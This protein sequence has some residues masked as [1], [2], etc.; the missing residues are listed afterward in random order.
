MAERRLQLEDVVNLPG[1]TH[2]VPQ[3]VR[4]AREDAHMWYLAGDTDPDTLVLWE[5]DLQTKQRRVV[6]SAQE[7]TYTP[8][9]ILRRERQRVRFDGITAYQVGRRGDDRVFLA[10]VGGRI[11]VKVGDRPAVSVPGVDGVEDPALLD[12]GRR[13]VYVRGGDLY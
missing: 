5:H 12:D 4:F 9:E 1:I 11:L 8:E 3:Q 2:Y 7:V 13:A 10:A 6:M